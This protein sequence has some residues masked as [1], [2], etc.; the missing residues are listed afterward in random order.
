MPQYIVRQR[1]WSLRNQDSLRGM[2]DAK[3]KF[4]ARCRG[5][6]EWTEKS[7][8][9]K[10]EKPLFKVSGDLEAVATNIICDIP[11]LCLILIFKYTIIIKLS[12][13]DIRE[14]TPVFH[15]YEFILY[16]FI[17]K[18]RTLRAIVGLAM[19]NPQN[20]ASPTQYTITALNRWSVANKQL[21]CRA[22]L[23]HAA[24][25]C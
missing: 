18:L 21:P 15:L 1:P 25:V 3:K 5:S 19:A 23:Y 2:E 12:F 24:I 4:I 16:S 11:N 9:P 13:R 6:R 7:P 14:L 20:G 10:E 8:R 17:K 22:N